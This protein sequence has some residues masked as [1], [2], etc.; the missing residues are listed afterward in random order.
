MG[1][2]PATF[3]ITTSLY[4]TVINRG[5]FSERVLNVLRYYSAHQQLLLESEFWSD[6][7]KLKLIRCGKTVFGQKRKLQY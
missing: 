7:Q 6:F 4:Y 1:F 3:P 5:I 2:E